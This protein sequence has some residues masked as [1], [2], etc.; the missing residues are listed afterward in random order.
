MNIEFLS[1]LH[2]VLTHASPHDLEIYR[3]KKDMEKK[4]YIR[5]PPSVEFSRG[6]HFPQDGYKKG[7]ILGG[8]GVIQ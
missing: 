1:C 8:I 6:G 2:A 7:Q 3:T 5:K 4:K